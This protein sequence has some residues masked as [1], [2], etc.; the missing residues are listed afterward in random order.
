MPFIFPFIF[1]QIYILQTISFGPGDAEQSSRA[2]LRE[3]V[4]RTIQHLYSSAYHITREK[5]HRGGPKK[6]HSSAF[7]FN[8][9]ER[10]ELIL[11]KIPDTV[12][13]RSL[14]LIYILTLGL[15]QGFFRTLFI[16]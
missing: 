15:G 1:G 13:P 7:L 5:S 8:S 12:C 9:K 6:L 2:N 4:Q 10:G 3:L 14:D 11:G 16:Q